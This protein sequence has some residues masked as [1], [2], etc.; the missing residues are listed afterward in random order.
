MINFDSAL[1]QFSSATNGAFLGSTGR[2][3]FCPPAV[4]NDLGGTQKQLRFGCVTSGSS[5]AGPTGGGLLA[6]IQWTPLNIGAAS[7]TLTPS[8]ADVFGNDIP[9]FALSGVI[10]ISSGPTPT[11]TNTPTPCP[12][13][14]PTDTPTATP[15]NTPSPTPTPNI[16]CGVGGAAVCVLPDFASVP[17]GTSLFADIDVQGASNLG[18]FEFTLSY[19]PGVLNATGVIQGTFLGATG[20]IVNCLTPHFS[21]GSVE[22]TC[23][24]LGDSPPGPNG[25][26]ILARV[27]F[28]AVEQGSSVLHLSDVTLVD[29]QANVLAATTVD[30]SRDVGP[31]AGVCPTATPTITETSTPTDTP[32]STATPSPT[33]CPSACPTDTPTVIPS[34]TSTPSDTPIP[35]TPSPVTL[36]I[37]PSSQTVIQGGGFTLDVVAENVSDVGAFDV[38][39]SFDPAIISFVSVAPGPF[40]GSTGRTVNCPSASSQSGLVRLGC[41]TLG[42][43]PAGASGSGVLASFHFSGGTPGLTG[44]SL[45]APLLTDTTASVIGIDTIVGASVTVEPCPGVCPTP[46]ATPTVGSPT[47]TSNPS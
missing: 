8:L 2:T 13:V 7:L 28:D 16:D 1:V 30:G 20:R 3:T 27:R 24:T 6:T 35:G 31:C 19:D 15:T 37:S 12:G 44:L 43:S 25:N 21:V 29:V 32:T 23:V 33:P 36:R 26:G 10:V 42:S 18:G 9:A 41:A 45:P 34:P 11:P 39:V 17:K 40:L 14:C 22:W 46:T 47:A 38:G 5:P 4:I